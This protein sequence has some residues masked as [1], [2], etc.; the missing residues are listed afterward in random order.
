[1]LLAPAIVVFVGLAGKHP[2]KIEHQMQ[3]VLAHAHVAKRAIAA[4]DLATLARHT[5]AS[6]DLVREMHVDGV[7]GGALIE[8]GGSLTLR[9]VIYDGEGNLKSLG[10]TPL[11]AR[12]MSKDEL[13]VL[14]D[15]LGE[16]LGGIT[17]KATEPTIEPRVA[18]P[19]T[20]PKPSAAPAPAPGLAEINFDTDEAKPAPAPAPAEQHR[21]DQHE[22]ESSDA[23]SL[24]DVASLNDSS[25]SVS[26]TTVAA[27]A[28][29]SDAGLHLHADAGFGVASRSFS[30]P[31]GVMGYSSSAVGTVHAEAG[32]S[33]MAHLALSAMAEEAL[34]MTSSVG[35]SMAS[36][37][38]S[39][40]EITAA[41]SLPIGR[42][43]IAPTVGLGQ[44][45]FS[46]D[47]SSSDRSPD[48]SYGYMLLG[49][50][51]SLPIGERI[52]A[53]AL[54]A[55]EPVTGG[56][57]PTAMAFGAATRWALDAGAGLDVTLFS[58]VTA[59]AAVDY[60]RFSWA[61]NAAGGRGAGGAVD[62]YPT[63]TLSVGAEY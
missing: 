35:R 18:L 29:A 2:E 46:I 51:A 13:E 60:Q 11:G 48:T 42:L 3:P 38:M 12:T 37:S 54:A 5:D 27:A 25:D 17:H 62:S 31:S 28:P 43:A 56:D 8:S 41:Y 40:W 30:G 32:L 36:T 7:I 22:A 16:E 49:A 6:R 21:D 39:R 44:R 34:D 10:E 50:T 61:W 47:S 4:R 9:V 1:M 55:F 24:A 58:H 45:N 14:G 63:G 20:A 59:R 26:A 33:P 53:R 52:T 23:V 57:D 15:N 19:K